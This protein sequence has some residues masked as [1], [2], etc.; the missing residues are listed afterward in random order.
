MGKKST[1]I[2]GVLAEKSTSVKGK[3]IEKLGFLNPEPKERSFNKERIKYWLKIGAK[4]SDTVY[5]LLV[6]EGIIKSEKIKINPPK[7]RRKKKN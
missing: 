4:L 3:Y 2:Q 6:S 1:F 7:K 5:N